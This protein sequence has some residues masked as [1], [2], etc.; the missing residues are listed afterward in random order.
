MKRILLLLILCI[1]SAFSLTSCNDTP[2]FEPAP[3]DS[4]HFAVGGNDFVQ[5]IVGDDGSIMYMLNDGCPLCGQTAWGTEV[6]K[7]PTC[8][9]SGVALLTC[10]DC[11]YA[12]RLDIEPSEEYHHFVD[13]DPE[14]LPY[15]EIC[16]A[17]S[18][19]EELDPENPDIGSED[20]K[21]P[22]KDPACTEHN[23]SDWYVLQSPTC[24]EGGQRQRSCVDCGEKEIDA[25]DAVG[26]SGGTASCDAQAI[27]TDCGLAYGGLSDHAWADASCEQ[28]KHCL[29]C[30]ATEGTAKGHTGGTAS[31]DQKAVCTRCGNEYG[32]LVA[33]SYSG[34]SCIR[35]GATDPSY[36]PSATIKNHTL[37]SNFPL[38]IDSFCGKI[39]SV[40]YEVN[41]DTLI[42][43]VH[44]K[45]T[46][47]Y[48]GELDFGWTIYGGTMANELEKGNYSTSTLDKGD[49][50]TATITVS[51]VITSDYSTYYVFWGSKHY[52]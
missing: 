50:F 2:D 16:G 3:E 42:M 38:D 8:V 45:R 26:H 34:G 37:S 1:C 49:T 15:C 9:D 46:A 36:K 14:Q 23:F 4:M 12:M 21:E 43:T 32:S 27:C 29:V 33:H 20:Q 31:C 51:G 52:N 41:G 30:S 5:I 40:S 6:L 48:S 18:Y 25:L 13:T 10:A 7:E 44:G 19:S 35:C 24:S 47:A 11:D 22:E 28:A 17:H 39:T